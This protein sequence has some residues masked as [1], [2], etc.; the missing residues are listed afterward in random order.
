MFLLIDVLVIKGFDDNDNEVECYVDDNE[1]FVV[2]VF[3]IVIDLFVG[4]LMFM[5]V[6]FGVV[7]LGDVVY[8]FVK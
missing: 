3:K 5:C 4:I 7:N 1:L 6:Y 2:L 8:N